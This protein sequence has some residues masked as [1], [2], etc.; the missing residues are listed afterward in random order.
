MDTEKK[1]TKLLLNEM[2]YLSAARRND[3]KVVVR[4]FY[5]DMEKIEESIR[6]EIGALPRR[7]RIAVYENLARF[8]DQTNKIIGFK[9]R[10]G[11]I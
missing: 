5:C 8:C 4:G 11:R 10:D 3:I 6:K 1:E 7:E 2:I 9:L